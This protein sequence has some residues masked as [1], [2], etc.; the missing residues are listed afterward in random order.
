MQKW[1]QIGEKISVEPIQKLVWSTGKNQEK[2]LHCQVAGY[3]ILLVHHCVPEIE[4]M[5]HG[6]LVWAQVWCNEP[7]T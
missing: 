6:I 2:K 4:I 5:N 7:P 1:G 3:S